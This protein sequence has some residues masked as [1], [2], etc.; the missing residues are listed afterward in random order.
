MKELQVGKVEGS[1]E[2]VTINSETGEIV[3]GVL[4]NGTVQL[5]SGLRVHVENGRV[6]GVA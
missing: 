6:T 5:Q 3:E 1:V 2:Q 4:Q